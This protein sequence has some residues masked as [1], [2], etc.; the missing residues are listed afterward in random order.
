MLKLHFEPPQHGWMMVRLDVEDAFLEFVAADVPTN[1]IHELADA[2]RMIPEGH[3][4]EVWWHLEPEGYFFVFEPVGDEVAF[5][6]YY[7]EDSEE[8]ER[9]EL[10]TL[11]GTPK[12]VLLP[13]WRALKEFQAFGADEPHWPP[14]EDLDW[15]EFEKLG[16]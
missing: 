1:P 4:A 14:L 9:R 6:V 12:E 3:P 7:A 5:T 11:R 8:E 10:A 2:L 15:G 13:F 16:G